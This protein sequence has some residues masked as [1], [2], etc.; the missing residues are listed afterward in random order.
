MLICK[1]GACQDKEYIFTFEWSDWNKSAND[2]IIEWCQENRRRFRYNE[3]FELVADVFCI[4]DYS[5]FKYEKISGDLY[6][7]MLK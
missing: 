4:N 1:G 3:Y 7:V 6:G 5:G 2:Y